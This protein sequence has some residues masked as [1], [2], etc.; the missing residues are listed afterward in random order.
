MRCVECGHETDLPSN[1]NPKSS[2]TC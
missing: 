1:G 2:A